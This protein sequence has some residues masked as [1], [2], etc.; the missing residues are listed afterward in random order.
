MSATGKTTAA[1]SST[2]SACSSTTPCTKVGP[3]S[4]LS[5]SSFYV[6]KECK[7][8]KTIVTDDLGH[9]ITLS[10]RYVEEICTCADTWT[11]EE[12]KTMTELAEIFLGSPRIAMTV[13][14][15]T[16]SS[17]KTKKDY[18]LEKA[19]KIDEI[20]NAPFSKTQQLVEDLIEN[21]LTRTIPGKNRVM[22]GRHYGHMDDLGRIHFI[23]MEITKDPTKDYDTRS[24]Q[25]DP[26]TILYLIVNKVK[27]T[28]K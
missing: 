27:Y 15:I 24:R 11:S 25:V 4:I 18:E 3:G 1:T 28:L 2:S 10:N 23:D 5:E 12:P 21:P 14:Y 20:L 19:T 7:G 26:R 8:D 22:K 9:E 6:V 16:K 13:C 17:E